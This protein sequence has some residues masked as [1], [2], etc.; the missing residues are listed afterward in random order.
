MISGPMR[1]VDPATMIAASIGPAH[2]TNTA[3]SASPTAK[4]LRWFETCFCG[5]QE[6]GFSSSRSTAGMSRPTPMRISTAMPTQR[7]MSCGSPSAPR[8]TE[9]TSVTSV[10]EV[11]SPRIT[12]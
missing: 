8:I 4:P 9:P 11:T 3:P 7:M 12:R 2:G 1:P 6:N 10:N 5:I